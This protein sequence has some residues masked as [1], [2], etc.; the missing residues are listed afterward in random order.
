M[1]LNAALVVYACKV[2]EIIM[3]TMLQT[4]INS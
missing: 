4:L 1:A 3:Y 2:H